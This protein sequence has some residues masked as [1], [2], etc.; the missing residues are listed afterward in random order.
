M[1]SIDLLVHR[2]CAP[3]AILT[4]YSELSCHD[5]A[6]PRPANLLEDVGVSTDRG[7]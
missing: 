5:M 3:T 4:H 6:H 1:L 2:S 7:L